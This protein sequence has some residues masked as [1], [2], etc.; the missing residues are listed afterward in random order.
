MSEN[1]LYSTKIYTNCCNGSCSCCGCGSNVGPAGPMGMQGPP[2][3]Q[4]PAGAQG[5]QGI[6]GPAGP[7]GPAGATGAT[8]AAG[9]QGPQGPQGEVGPAGPV[10]ATGATG[11]TGPAGPAGATGATGATGPAGPTG[12]TGPAGPAG[13][14]ATNENAML[15]NAAGQTVA[16]GDTLTFAANQINST[17]SIALDGTD[18]LTLQP[19]QYLVNFRTDADNTAV[20]SL[21]AA[22][23][24]DGVALP[25]ATSL[26]ASPAAETQ[27]LMLTAV[28]DLTAA[29][30]LT[31]INNSGD[32]NT[33]TNSTLAVV[34][35]A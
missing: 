32:T 17:G 23:A 20:G 4:G 25:Y 6:P 33:Y 21:G 12:A 16:A 11:A 27:S 19:G 26:A 18:G 1:D 29:Q 34:R 9:P 22:L 28:L 15:Y 30:T 8:G 5:P 7:A 10:G 13:A 35:L 3:P 2:G 24:L 14:T 31:V